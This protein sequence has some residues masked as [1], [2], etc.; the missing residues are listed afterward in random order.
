MARGVKRYDEVLEYLEN[1]FRMYGKMP[2]MKHVAH[3]LNVMRTTVVR[4]LQGLER[5]G[6]LVRTYEMPYRFKS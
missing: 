3:D 1:Y 5:E 2:T 6:K 4:V